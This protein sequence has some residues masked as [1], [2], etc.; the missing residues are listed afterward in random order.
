M[1]KLNGFLAGFSAIALLASCSND[2]PANGG[3]G[4]N[5]PEGELAYM[6]ITINDVNASRSTEGGDLTPSAIENEHSVK[7]VRF[8]FYDENGNLV[9]TASDL[10]PGVTD[11]G[12]DRPN[13]EYIGTQSILVLEGLK[14]NTFPSYMLTVIN[15]PDFNAEGLT[16]ENAGLSLANYKNSEGNF[17]MTTSSFKGTKDNHNDKYYWATKLESKNFYTSEAA[18]R[19]DNNPVQVY[20]ERL[21]A[22]V[23]VAITATKTENGLYKLNQTLSGVDN[24]TN[25]D[26]TADA[27]LYL[28]VVGWGLNGTAEKSYLSKQL[29]LDWTF[30]N[31][32]WNDA[33]RWRSYWSKSCLYGKTIDITTGQTGESGLF[34]NYT[35]APELNKE[36][37]LEDVA[38]KVAYCNENTN[39]PDMIT[40]DKTDPQG[41]SYKSVITARTTHV[42]LKTQVCKADGT[43]IDLITYRGMLFTTEY[44][45]ATLLNQIKNG[46]SKLNFYYLDASKTEDNAT[47]NDYVQVSTEDLK[48]EKDGNKLGVVK[49]ILADESKQLYVKTTDESGDHFKKADTSNADQDLPALL[50]A[51]QTG[52]AINHHDG[53]TTYWI[54][55]EHLAAVEMTGNKADEGYYGVVRNHWYQLNISQFSKVGHGVFDPENGSEII[56]PD[57]PED[58]FYYL[59]ARINI[60]SWKIVKQNVTL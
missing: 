39:T 28:K 4:E 47:V 5:K 57:D 58:V 40:E 27:E 52:E 36:F 14:S 48:V 35:T 49:I 32:T 42:V 18:A 7:N 15:A 11:Q 12:A 41:A 24:S 6:T 59:A 26:N 56:I 25:G 54:P 8:F 23:Q 37:G 29:N 3:N 13:V 31:W 20:V 60:L 55:I 19:Q 38:A 46:S 53:Y 21:A 43:P 16:L 30:A 34:L 51:A 33:D 2:E 17:V 44:Y 22:K 9:H 45:M 10:T 1:K 50:A